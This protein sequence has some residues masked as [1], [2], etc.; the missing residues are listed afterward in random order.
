MFIHPY[1]L[2]GLA[3][4]GLPILI[5]LA[6]R[7]KPRRLSFPAFR[8]L[9]LR[10]NIN[11][12]RLRL[13]HLLLLLLRIGLIVA[14]CLALARPQVASETAPADTAPQVAAVFLFDT[15]PSMGYK[16][17][18]VTRLEEAQQHALGLLDQMDER[19]RVVILDAGDHAETKGDPPVPP[20]QARKRIKGLA[21]RPVNTTMNA[22]LPRAYRSLEVLAKADGTLPSLLYV[23]SDRT[24]RSRTAGP[25]ARRT[26]R[27]AAGD[28][29]FLADV[30][31]QP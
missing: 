29:I 28:D 1:L 22:Q 15:S 17:G 25:P 27:K 5:H 24:N 30:V 4:A 23:F 9:K 12:R 16:L 31:S 6:M 10:H 3:L 8:F 19:S 2:F 11:R 13:Q 21:L 7:Q 14:L 26:P 20:S 18:P